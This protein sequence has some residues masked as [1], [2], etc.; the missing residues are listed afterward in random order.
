MIQTPESRIGAALAAAALLASYSVTKKTSSALT[1]DNDASSDSVGMVFKPGVKN[2][3]HI[4]RIG[5]DGQGSTFRWRYSI[6]EGLTRSSMPSDIA[7]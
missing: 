1:C 3:Q 4:A 6:G 2:K 5:R 7:C